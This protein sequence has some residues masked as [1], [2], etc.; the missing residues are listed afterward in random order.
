MSLYKYVTF[1]TLKRILGGSIRYSQPGALNDPFEM[2][3]ELYVPEE[4]GSQEISIQFSVTASRREPM[5]AGWVG[6]DFNSD[7]V[8]DQNS[9]NILASLNESI[10]I[11]CLSK[12]GSS[13]LMWSHY[14]KSYSGAIVEFDESHEFFTGKFDMIYSEERPKI[15][16]ESYID[17][18]EPVPIA[19]LCVKEKTWEHEREVRVVRSLSDCRCVGTGDDGF[20]IYVADVPRECIKAVIIGERMTVGQQ[21]E[22]WELVKDMDDVSLHLDAVANWGYGF[23]REHIKLPG[24]TGMSPRTAHIFADQQGALGDMAR[25]LIEKHPLSAMV[26]ATL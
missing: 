20:P 26:N 9:R 1:K 13:L 7:K 6:S 11:L 4:F 15:S 19:E 17:T 23:R 2:V 21:R 10:G 3:P 25:A 8:S 14:A 5:L 12:N 22:I 18:E 16:V 24:L